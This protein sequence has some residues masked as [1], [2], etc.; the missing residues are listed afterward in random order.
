MCSF[1]TV[2][3]TYT[4]SRYIVANAPDPYENT[5]IDLPGVKSPRPPA[6][7]IKDANPIN[8]LAVYV[9]PISLL[10]ILESDKRFL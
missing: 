9:F 2:L 6:R 4:E 7:S 8:T 1:G 3:V 10:A 5:A